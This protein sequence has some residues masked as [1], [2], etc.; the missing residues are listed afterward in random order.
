[1]YDFLS[2]MACMIVLYIFFSFGRAYQQTK[3]SKQKGKQYKVEVKEAIG[4]KV[5]S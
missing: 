4:L 5:K 2:G 3:M 1:M